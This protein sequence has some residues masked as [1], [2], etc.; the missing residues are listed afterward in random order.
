MDYNL[1]EAYAHH[2]VQAVIDNLEDRE[3]AR[4]LQTALKAE[5]RN[6][7]DE[8]RESYKSVEYQNEVY[9][10]TL[11]Y[12]NNDMTRSFKALVKGLIE[13]KG[14]KRKSKEAIHQFY[15]EIEDQC[16]LDSQD[17]IDGFMSEVENMS[18]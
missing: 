12:I 11:F 1:L 17:C 18:L 3:L 9:S 8:I 5:R 15:L 16:M 7:E 2:G 6:L 14:G 13:A 10:N 4:I